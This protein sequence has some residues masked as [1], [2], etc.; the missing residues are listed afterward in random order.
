MIEE[1]INVDFLQRGAFLVLSSSEFID[2]VMSCYLGNPRAKRH[3]FIFL[4]QH[5]VELQENFRSGVLSIFELAEKLSAN[6][7][8]VA[9]VSDVEHS[10]KFGR[11]WCRLNDCSAHLSFLM[12]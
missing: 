10:Q 6:L 5:S 7:Q 12:R 1:A 8:N 4:V 2:T 9:I 3:H 11:D